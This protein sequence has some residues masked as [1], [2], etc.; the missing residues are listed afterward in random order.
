[1]AKDNKT[2]VYHVNSLKKQIKEKDAEIER[3][4][5]YIKRAQILSERPLTTGD[6]AKKCFVHLRTVLAWIAEG[7]LKARRTPG[8]HSR[9]DVVDFQAFAKK[10][11]FP[12]V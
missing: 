10:Y 6:V 8:G 12:G 7:K 4:R 1:M 11:G 9:I 3:L 2:I 5:A